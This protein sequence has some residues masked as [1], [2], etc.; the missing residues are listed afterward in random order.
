M[1]IEKIEEIKGKILSILKRYNV[2]RAGIFGS[3]V[4][5]EENKESDIDILVE[6]VGR[7]SLLDFA[8]LKLELEEALGQRVDLG[9]YSTIK[10]MIKEQIL[11][12]EVSIL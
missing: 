10:P 3:V 2:K 7:M 9:E 6:I 8:G 5:G 12:E 1:N 11:S 4:R